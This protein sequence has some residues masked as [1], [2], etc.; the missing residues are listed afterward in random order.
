MEPLAINAVA[1]TRVCD[2]GGW[3]DTHFARV[4]AVFNVATYPCVEVQ[5]WALGPAEAE[6]GVVISA[7]NFGESYVVDPD[8]VVYGKH[9][10]LEAAI[11][12]MEIPR[13]V[14]LRINSFSQ[15]PRA[16]RWGRPR[17]SRWRSS[18]P[19]TCCHQGA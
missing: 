4:G 10:L 8:H 17:R 6:S 11:K 13:D 2:V 18:A 1:P 14:A 9:P 12:T 3:T 15:P 16:P 19:S 5:L 7:E